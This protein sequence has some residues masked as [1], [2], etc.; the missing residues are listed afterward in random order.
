VGDVAG[1]AIFLAGEDAGFITG[2]VYLAVEAAQT[3]NPEALAPV[4]E[5]TDYTGV[6]G[7]WVFTDTHNARYGDGYRVFPMARWRED[8]SRAVVWPASLATG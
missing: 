2:G 6:V 4:L 3:I 5:K 8:G 1:L 7:R